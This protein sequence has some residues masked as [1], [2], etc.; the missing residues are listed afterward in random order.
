MGED[1]FYSMWKISKPLNFFFYTLQMNLQKN[2][3]NNV[4]LAALHG[5]ARVKLKVSEISRT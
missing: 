1:F 3:N 5:F 2:N 4:I